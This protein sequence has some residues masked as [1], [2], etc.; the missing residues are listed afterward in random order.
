MTNFFKFSG[1]LISDPA[2][3]IPSLKRRGKRNQTEKDEREGGGVD[4]RA[5]TKPRPSICSYFL[6]F[7]FQ[8]NESFFPN[9]YF[10]FLNARN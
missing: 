10:S 1:E 6:L 5:T 2:V 4:K 7:P 3:L 8:R 9:R